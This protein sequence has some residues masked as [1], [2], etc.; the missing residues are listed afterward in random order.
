MHGLCIRACHTCMLGSIEMGFERLLCDSN[1]P[2][3]WPKT[4]ALLL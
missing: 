4:F 3:S 2:D 1:L